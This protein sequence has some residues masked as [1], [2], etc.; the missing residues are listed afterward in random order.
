[1][2]LDLY[3]LFQYYKG[4]LIQTEKMVKYEDISVK[5]ILKTNY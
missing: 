2:N 3:I 1:M 4:I 5:K